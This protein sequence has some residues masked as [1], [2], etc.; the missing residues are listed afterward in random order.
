[1]ATE[2]EDLE[3]T[4]C[5]CHNVSFG[6]LLEAI[7]AGAHTIHDIQSET[8]ASTGCGGCEWEVTEILEQEQAKLP[9]K[10]E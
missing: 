6:K 7:R 4:V 8:C 9:K 3:R 10:P 1:M 2:D 5:F